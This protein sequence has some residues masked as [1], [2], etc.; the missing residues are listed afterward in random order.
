MTSVVLTVLAFLRDGLLAWFVVGAC[1]AAI[2][3]LDGEQVRGDLP[4]A[5]ALGPYTLL[6]A[7]IRS[8]GD[9]Q[10]IRDDGPSSCW[11]C[12]AAIS[13]EPAFCARCGASVGDVH[14]APVQPRW[15]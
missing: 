15:G 4:R 12:A 7:L 3:F 2:R 5:I 13:P 8:A 11:R 10:S 1:A 9:D 6:T 14:F